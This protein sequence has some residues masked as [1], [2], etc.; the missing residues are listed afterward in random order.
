M[1][2]KKSQIG[3]INQKLTK[4]SRLVRNHLIKRHILH[5]SKQL[6]KSNANAINK[7]NKRYRTLALLPKFLRQGTNIS[8]VLDDEKFSLYLT[9]SSSRC[10]NEFLNN[11]S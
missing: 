4:R 6:N 1:T 8:T 11:K 3:L 7:V 2:K 10:K 9:L 5:R